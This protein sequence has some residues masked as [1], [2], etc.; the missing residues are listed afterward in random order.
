[1]WRVSHEWLGPD[2]LCHCRQYW[3]VVDIFSISTHG[4]VAISHFSTLVVL[5]VDV[6]LTCVF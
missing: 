3:R 5:I 4:R 1:M 2:F 6:E